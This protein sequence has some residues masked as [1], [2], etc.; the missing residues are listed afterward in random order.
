MPAG[1][2]RIVL[3]AGKKIPERDRIVDYRGKI[4]LL[5]RGSD[6]KS[7]RVWSGRFHPLYP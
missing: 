1:L 3:R 5:Q 2:Q 7:L 4:Y 6:P